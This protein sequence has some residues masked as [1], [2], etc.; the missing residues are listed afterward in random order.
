MHTSVSRYE[1]RP[2]TA[3]CLEDA[4]QLRA[5]DHRRHRAAMPA[6]DPA[7]EDADA[8]QPEIAALLERERSSGVLV[9]VAGKP[10]AY[11]LG[12]P[13]TD[14]RWGSNVFVDDAGFGGDDAESIRESYAAAAREWV[15]AGFA[16]Q[17]VM[18]N[19]ADAIQIEAWFSLCFGKQHIHALR[20]RASPDYRPRPRDGLLI[21]LKERRDMPALAELR[22]VVPA[23]VR[24]SPTFSFISVPS[25]EEALAEAEEDFEDERFTEFVAEHEGRVLGTAV[26][27]SL[28]ESGMTTKLMRPRSAGFLAHAAVLP[29]GRGLGVGRALGEAIIAWSRDAG[30]EWT[31]SDWRSANLEANRTWRSLGFVPSFFRLHRLIG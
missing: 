28:Q 18:V 4:A 26:A 31:A 13:R 2:F 21:R 23:H 10:V 17:S 11:L 14:P 20:E 27:C 3:D 6:L 12:G 16:N 1:T 7:F 9:S 5:A 24:T 25:F 30:Y 29:E 15:E 19:A 22:R 8:V